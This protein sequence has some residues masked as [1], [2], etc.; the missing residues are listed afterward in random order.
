MITLCPKSFGFKN[1][2]LDLKTSGEIASL[3]FP[4]NSSAKE[5][6]TTSTS[7]IKNSNASFTN[8]DC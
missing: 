1:A 3:N 2:I 7:E 8:W 4:K 6:V 5:L